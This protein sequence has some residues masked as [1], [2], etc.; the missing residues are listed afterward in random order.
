MRPKTDKIPKSLLTVAE[1]PFV[2]HQLSLLAKNGVRDVIFCLGY[3]GEMVEAYTNECRFDI[4]I[5]YSYDGDRLLGTGGA[6]RKAVRDEPGPFFVMYGDSY[7]DVDYGS[8]ASA[9]AG[10]DKSGLMTIYR[11]DNKYDSGNVIYSNGELLVYSKRQRNPEM[12]YIDYGLGVLTADVFDYALPDVQSD[13]AD[14]YERLAKNGRLYG[15]EIY[16][17]FY[18]VGSQS[19][20]ADLEAYLTNEQSCVP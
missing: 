10:C 8:I 2:Y 7:L 12:R 5:H 14:V 19:G 15:Y 6:L 9:Y 20:L 13:L 4:V 16:N 3:K 1:K 11:N 18:E 17:R